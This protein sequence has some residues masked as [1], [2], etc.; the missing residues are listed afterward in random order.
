MVL[1]AGLFE[2]IKVYMDSGIVDART[3][4]QLY[5]YRI[6]ELLGNSSVCCY[7]LNERRH[8]WTKFIELCEII[9]RLDRKLG[10]ERRLPSLRAEDHILPTTSGPAGA[11]G[12]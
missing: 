11:S 12:K 10:A 3:I 6:K 4:Y 8:G 9:E 5:G 7:I 2:R 1:Y